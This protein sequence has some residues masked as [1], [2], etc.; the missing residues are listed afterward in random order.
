MRDVK[1]TDFKQ[2]IKSVMG[3][4]RSDGAGT[5]PDSVEAL[6]AG[7]E[8]VVDDDD[9][10]E[11][12]SKMDLRDGALVKGSWS[13]N[14][15]DGDRAGVEQRQTTTTIDR[16]KKKFVNGDSFFTTSSA[17]KKKRMM[18]E[19]RNEGSPEFVRATS[20]MTTTTTTNMTIKTASGGGGENTRSGGSFGFLSPSKKL[21]YGGCEKS[22]SP[23]GREGLEIRKQIGKKNLL[24]SPVAEDFVMTHNSPNSAAFEKW[25][26]FEDVQHYLSGSP[27][28]F[29]IKHKDAEAK[30]TE[31]KMN[32]DGNGRRE[33]ISPLGG[34]KVPQFSLE[35]NSE[36][37]E[38]EDR[39][40]GDDTE[41]GREKETMYVIPPRLDSNAIEMMSSPLP[42]LELSGK[43][44]EVDGRRTKDVEKVGFGRNEKCDNEDDDDDE[45]KAAVNAWVQD[46]KI[47]RECG[48]SDE[49]RAVPREVQMALGILE[50]DE[51]NDR[52]LRKR[53][54]EVS[55]DD[56]ENNNN[57][58]DTY[59]YDVD[60][61]QEDMDDE[62]N[63]NN[64]NNNN[65]A[66]NSEEKIEVARKQNAYMC[67]RC[68]EMFASRYF[69]NRHFEQCGINNNNNEQQQN[70]TVSV[71]KNNNIMKNKIINTCSK[72]GK[73]CKNLP[74]KN[75]HE[76]TCP[77]K[78][79]LELKEKEDAAQ[80]VEEEKRRFER[81][82]EKRIARE[83]EHKMKEAKKDEA[84]RIEEQRKADIER[85]EKEMTEHAMSMK[86]AL[87]E[88]RHIESQE[89]DR[90]LTPIAAISRVIREKLLKPSTR[91]ASLN[92][93]HEVEIAN[94]TE[95]D[96]NVNVD[97]NGKD[98]HSLIYSL[99]RTR[100]DLVSQLLPTVSGRENSIAVCLSGA[101]GVGKTAVVEAALATLQKLN[102]GVKKGTEGKEVKF[103]VVRLS[104]LIHADDSIG[105]REVA[106]QLRPS[107]Q[108][109][110]DDEIDDDEVFDNDF[111]DDVVFST[112]NSTNATNNKVASN[113][114]ENYNFVEETLRLL[115]GAKRTAVF[116]LDDFDL[117]ARK[118]KKQT[119]LY[120]MLDLLQQKHAQIAIIAVTSRHDVEEIL[121]K[122]VKS[123]FTARYCVIES[124]TCIAPLC[125]DERTG[126]PLQ[127]QNGKDRVDETSIAT[128]PKQFEEFLSE[129]VRNYL[130]VV[131]PDHNNNKSKDVNSGVPSVLF[132][133]YG[134][135]AIKMWNCAVNIAVNAPEVK[136]RLQTIATLDNV[137]R[138][139]SDIAI[140]ALI[141]FQARTMFSGSS[142]RA[143]TATGGG[144]SNLE[145]HGNNNNRNETDEKF[146]SSDLVLA[147]Q[148]FTRNA[149]VENLK[150]CSLLE[151]LLCVAAYRL[152]FTRDR[153][154]F[155][156]AALTQEL[157]EMGSVEQ[158]GAAKDATDGVVA[159]SFE[160]LL[161]MKL[162]RI[163]K[164]TN[165]DGASQRYTKTSSAT[166]SYI[167]ANNSRVASANGSGKDW[168]GIAL[169][170]TEK[171][172][173]QAIDGH[174]SKL[175]SLKEF[176]RHENV[177]GQFWG[178]GSS[179]PPPP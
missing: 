25:N 21:Q 67:E 115:E 124:Q 177:V 20:M 77:G 169:M 102:N 173:S 168:K 43:E 29:E 36:K 1:W 119:F 70:E 12:G 24:I 64:N 4:R 179:S 112:G 134:K 74:G 146:S 78:E 128:N 60:Y 104:G 132:T 107:Y 5:G 161:R 164:Q 160:T 71:N 49:D 157:R 123:R 99:R 2:K 100:D 54:D 11:K 81:A 42:P 118:G 108:M 40:K 142:A 14:E 32:G 19:E 137:P 89:R 155:T 174:P 140:S 39:R 92:D 23:V 166:A 6:N 51:N 103:P 58:L 38:E 69:F 53:E 30:K 7:V 55:D 83:Q 125:I 127:D 52:L 8:R 131:I 175:S 44:N 147:L 35:E 18:M 152:H 110:D 167:N 138:T 73:L 82:E 26:N 145:T 171:E 109:W 93:D 121:E 94:E 135:A 15:G 16:K 86:K 27:G 65:D 122:R 139:A 10:R 172:L 17:K 117:F 151:L 22:S 72:C 154:H 129:R 47:L 90:G 162:V 170:C 75:R 59:G 105:M 97:R 34:I 85:Y 144:E 66:N 95:G 37:E 148:E 159:R 84:R 68:N 156:I 63:N 13:N 46:K 113:M 165:A 116:V 48:V 143:I 62:K 158:L 96:D 3:F 101:R 114:R 130:K 88:T 178:L 153:F 133:E 56:T 61:D 111:V 163:V 91:A 87:A 98:D 141:A 120:S 136:M 76:Q 57:A 126:K 33:M 31:I 28:G 106:R 50:D 79:A 9:A 176:L 150:S 41:I 149:F 80:R 45:I